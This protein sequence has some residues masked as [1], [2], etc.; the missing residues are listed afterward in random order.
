M[1]FQ[2][3]LPNGLSA[4][5][6]MAGVFGGAAVLSVFLGIHIKEVMSA[7][8]YNVL[9]ILVAMD[10][11][12]KLIVKTG[13]MQLL[14]T[15][16]AIA[17]NGNLRHIAFLFGLLMFLVS[18]F[19]NNITAVMII[20]PIVFVMLK[21]LYVDRRYVNVFFAIIL[22]LCNTGGASSPIGDFPAIVIMT[23]GITTFPDYLLRAMPLFFATSL[24]LLAVWIPQIRKQKEMT[25]SKFAV[26][27]LYSRYKH[28]KV[29]YSTLLPLLII[30]V[31]MFFA[32]SFVPQNVLP[33]ETI[34][35]LGYIAA[36]FVCSARG[37]KI[38]Q[39]LD[40]KSVLTISAF[41]FMAGV[42]S[43]TGWLTDMANVLQEN[44][45]DP[46]ILLIAIMLITSIVS[47]VF[48]AGPA[49][50]AMM[51]VIAGLCNTTLS[52]QTHWVAIAYA[53]SICAGSSLFMWSATAGFIL[54]D[55]IEKAKLTESG[56]SI[57]WGI[58]NYF[59]YGIVNYCAQMAIAIAAMI[60]IL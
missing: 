12:T 36:A 37:M 5:M 38:N 46:K 19:L 26:H 43:K 49:A 28:V 53:A 34:A 51:P 11:F 40:F 52:A 58:V 7:Y 21:S 41:L 20:L 54:S 45:T 57:P 1:F 44:I 8:Q 14:A 9:V 29:D 4:I 24:I 16:I 39:E 17:S 42:I 27:L 60:I 3:K 15:K 55:K 13:I 47:G 35:V 59:R 23:S 22:A 33:P 48:S 56:Q 10:L 25:T 31:L 32:W 18:A 6:L 2:D 50:A 30:L